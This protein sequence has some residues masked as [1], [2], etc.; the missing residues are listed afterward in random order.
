MAKNTKYSDIRNL[1]LAI[2][3]NQPAG[4]LVNVYPMVIKARCDDNH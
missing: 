2:S 1:L 3:F 4:N